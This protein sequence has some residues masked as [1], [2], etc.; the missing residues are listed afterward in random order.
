LEKG[1]KMERQP[2]FRFIHCSDLHLDSPF[3]G[4]QSVEPWVADILRKATFEAFQR[5]GKMKK[6]K[7][8]ILTAS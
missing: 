1:L 2:L 5:R 6:S 8:E 3:E 7:D 4:I